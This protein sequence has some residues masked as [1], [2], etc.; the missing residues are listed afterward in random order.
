[1]IYNFL[2]RFFDF[3]FGISLLILISP[4]FII[5]I[6]I[7]RF[8]GEKEVFYL[9]KRIGYKNKPFLI[10]KF[11]TMKK[12]SSNIGLK[13]LTIKDDPRV[14]VFGKILRVTK[15]NELPQIINV[16]KGDVSFVGPRPLMKSS[17]EQYDSF[18]QNNI[19]NVRPGITGI[20]SIIFRDEETLISDLK[21]IEPHEF[22]RNYISPYKGSV[23]IWYQK[24]ISFCLDIKL[25]FI[26]AWVIIMKESKIYERIFKDLPKRNF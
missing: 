21:N 22:Y 9:Q 10:W 3:F 15:L 23:E 13:D 18:Y 20:G 19:Y 6:L 14:T 7:L 2:K 5:L 25:L 24:K 1:M 12:N 8:T 17:F 4:L 16:I 26:T 11:A